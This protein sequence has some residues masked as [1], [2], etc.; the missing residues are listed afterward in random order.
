MKTFFE[1]LPNG[2]LVNYSLQDDG[3]MLSVTEPGGSP[4]YWKEIRSTIGELRNM[5]WKVYLER[6]EGSR[7]S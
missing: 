7:K 2:T 3:W 1:K 5:V 4:G 6:T